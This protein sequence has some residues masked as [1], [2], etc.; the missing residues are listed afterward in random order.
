MEEKSRK[1]TILLVDDTP[2]TIGVVKTALEEEGY[3][4]FV[5]TSG[6]KGIKRTERTMPDLILLDVR[7]P[8]MDGFE[9]CRR[10]KVNERTSAIPVIFMTGL[11]ATE[12]KVTGFEIGGVDYVTKPIN[13]QELLARVKTHL[14]LRR[15][16]RE[17]EQK[18]VS[19]EATNKT[20][21]EFAYVVS[22]DL[23]APLRGINHLAH[24]LVEDY[25][26]AFDQDGKEKIDLLVGRVKYM[27]SLIDG[28]LRYSRVGRIA[29]AEEQID[30]HHL[31]NGVID[32]IAPPESIR[33][34]IEKELPHITG[35]RLRFKR[36]FKIY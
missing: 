33:I 18:N 23:K 1:G 10:L 21:E 7:M 4:V 32:L 31:V 6:D 11:T 5:A 3:E 29:E 36:Y 30:L 25:A 24:W 17:L 14:S 20:L 13:L 8:G 22:H 15:L 2:P 16:R 28:I 12:S 35:D 27:E 19:L 9:T 26:D 34:T